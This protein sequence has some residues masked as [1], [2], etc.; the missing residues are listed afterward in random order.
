MTSFSLSAPTFQRTT[1]NSR[2]AFFEVSKKNVHKAGEHLHER[3]VVHL[4]DLRDFGHPSFTPLLTLRS[5]FWSSVSYRV[6][7]FRVLISMPYQK[8]LRATS[9]AHPLPF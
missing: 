9:S 2:C 4:V 7:F 1:S 6:R 8:G 5:I 3:L